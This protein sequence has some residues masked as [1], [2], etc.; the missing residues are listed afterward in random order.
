MSWENHGEWHLD[1]VIPLSYFDLNDE[2]QRLA[3][4]HYINFQPLW[5]ADNL[6]KGGKN[7]IERQSRVTTAFTEVGH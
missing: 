6:K 7:R 3:A 1:H 5:A 2:L 4:W